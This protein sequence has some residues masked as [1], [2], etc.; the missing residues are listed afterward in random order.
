M[1]FQLREGGNMKKQLIIMALLTSIVG[2]L[3]GCTGGS[4]QND[5]THANPAQNPRAAV[6]E[7]EGNMTTGYTWIVDGIVPD[8][9]VKEVGSDYVT[10]EAPENMVGVGGT[11]MFTFESIAPGEAEVTFLYL[12]EWE[13]EEYP[14]RAVYRAT[15]DEEGTLTMEKTEHTPAGFP[16]T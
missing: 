2:L 4:A 9:V 16:T 7:L 12:R 11:F 14:E 15:V 6:V 13:D 8:G 10:D 5:D 1:M 3:V